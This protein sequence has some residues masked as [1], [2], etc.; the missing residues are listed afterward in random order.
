MS[1]GKALL[2]DDTHQ[3]KPRLTWTSFAYLACVVV[4]SLLAGLV[5]SV[6]RFQAGTLPDQSW[7]IPS[8][9]TRP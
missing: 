3:E 7:S 9:S 6:A 8:P 1:R 5:R 2:V 4:L